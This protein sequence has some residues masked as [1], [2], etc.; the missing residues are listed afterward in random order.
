[1]VLSVH[2]EGGIWKEKNTHYIEKTAIEQ[3]ADQSEYP[4]V[5]RFSS[6]VVL[7]T[8][9]WLPQL[10]VLLTS[11]AAW[12]DPTQAFTPFQPE[13]GYHVSFE[14]FDP[15]ARLAKL[16]DFA[17]SRGGRTSDIPGHPLLFSVFVDN[18]EL[19]PLGLLELDPRYT[20]IR[21]FTDEAYEVV[22]QLVLLLKR[23]VCGLH[24]VPTGLLCKAAMLCSTT[25]SIHWIVALW[26][27]PLICATSFKKGYILPYPMT[28]IAYAR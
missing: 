4:G 7:D 27:C 21:R 17:Y 24:H 28:T 6:H 12:K 23:T 11:I 1:M 10:P 26:P 2:F 8:D 15:D 16:E 9:G 5:P 22:D 18:E 19:A 20:T 13:L 25:S 14:D 3:R